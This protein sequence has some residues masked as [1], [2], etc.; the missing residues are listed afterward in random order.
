MYIFIKKKLSVNYT[1]F[2]LNQLKCHLSIVVYNITVYIMLFVVSYFMT[3]SLKLISNI[4]TC[5]KSKAKLGL[6]RGQGPI[7]FYEMRILKNKNIH[8]TK[9]TNYQIISN[10]FIKN[11]CSSL[12]LVKIFVVVNNIVQYSIWYYHM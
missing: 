10:K 6:K 5:L 9:F 3:H 2:E 4:M 8:I 7:S 1:H 12:K 11:E